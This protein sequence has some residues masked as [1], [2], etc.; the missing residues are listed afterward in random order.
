MLRDL[1][2][3]F[4]LPFFDFSTSVSVDIDNLALLISKIN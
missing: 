3:P 1:L 2:L 4:K